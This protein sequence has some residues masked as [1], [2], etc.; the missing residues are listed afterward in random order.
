MGMHLYRFHFKLKNWKLAILAMIFIAIFTSLG[1]WQLSRANSKKKLLNSFAA[2]MDQPALLSTELA[3]N[4][5]FRFY[6]VELTG[7]FDTRHI[8]LLD[9]KIFQGKIG[10]EIYVPF[11]A[12]E[13]AAP[14]LVDL[15]F[16]GM[17]QD[18]NKLPVIKMN[19]TKIHING[20]LNLPPK[21]F[22]FGP[23][24]DYQP[25]TWP[26]RVEF[27]NLQ[28]LAKLTGY[29]LFSYVMMVDPKHPQAFP[30]EWQITPMKPEKHLAYAI[31]WFALA[32]TLLILFLVLNLEMNLRS[33][34]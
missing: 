9:N 18:R 13:M 21:Y 16:I 7:Q 28:E 27:I 2:R 19:S 14:I 25:I 17:G 10:Y 8:F 26:L 6:K 32:L 30:I 22:A 5:D 29:P 24:H 12:Q 34:P 20:L 23:M 31:Q 4:N 3:K 15:G 11:K 33:L 1:A